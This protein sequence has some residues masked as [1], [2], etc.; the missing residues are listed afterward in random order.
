MTAVYGAIWAFG[1]DILDLRKK[2]GEEFEAHTSQPLGTPL[3]KYEGQLSLEDEGIS[4]VG[5]SKDSHKEFR[6]VVPFGDVSDV[7]LGWDD[8]LRRWKDT[9][10]L[11]KPLRITFENQGKKALYIYAKR[12]GA[13]I[14]GKQNKTLYERLKVSIE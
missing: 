13:R 12:V 2:L 4:L 1:E 3:H 11:I 7:Y 6:L 8:V 9:R 14:Y 5:E 10:A